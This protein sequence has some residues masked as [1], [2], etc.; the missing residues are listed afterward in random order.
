LQL[1]EIYNNIFIDA[2]STL[3]LGQDWK[4]AA[5]TI[6]A[7][8]HHFLWSDIM[9]DSYY[10]KIAL[11]EASKAYNKGEIP[12]GAVIVENGVIIS[13]GHNL[14]DNKKCVIMHAEIIA[15]EKANRKKKDWRLNECT[16]YITLEPCK[17][18]L[19][20]IEQARI[21]RVVYGTSA[22]SSYDKE[23]ENKMIENVAI[24][25]ECSGLLNDF[26]RNLRDK[27]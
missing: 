24:S 23:V 6:Q 10:M 2:M 14:R 4:I 13:K 22:I 3:E 17:M 25:T 8:V 11:K 20:A 7:H 16:I 5:L 27:K 1:I 12:V 21:K 15:M 26:F 19:G 9:D 18:C